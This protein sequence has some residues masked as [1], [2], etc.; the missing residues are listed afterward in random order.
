MKKFIKEEA[1]YWDLTVSFV[2]GDPRLVLLDKDDKIVKKIGLT[3]F[4]RNDLYALLREQGIEKI[5]DKEKRLLKER[6]E[7]NN[8]K[9]KPNKKKNYH[10][11]K[12]NSQDTTNKKNDL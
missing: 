10:I 2:G 1:K 12:K 5:V 9:V 3:A 7:I 11:N 6:K 8:G 4:N